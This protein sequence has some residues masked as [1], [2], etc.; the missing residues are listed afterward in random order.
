M[1][2]C[3]TEYFYTEV[4]VQWFGKKFYWLLIRGPLGRNY[5]SCHYPPIV[6]QL[7]YAY[8]VSFFVVDC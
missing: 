5:R 1:L 3:Y 6:A 7:G 8:K 4:G 2:T